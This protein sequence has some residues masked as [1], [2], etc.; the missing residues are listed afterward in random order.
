MNKRNLHIDL[1]EKYLDNSLRTDEVALFNE[2]LENEEEFVRD[3]NDMEV[4]IAGIKKAAA[5]TTIEE[6]IDRFERTV[7]ITENDEKNRI[8]FPDFEHIK[9]YSGAIAASLT[10]ILVTT[11]TLFNVNNTPDHQKLYA[12]YYMPFEN[13]GNKRSIDIEDKNYWKLALAYYDAGQYDAALANLDQIKINDFKGTFNSPSYHLYRGNTLM[14]LNRH[15]E[16]IVIFEKMIDNEDGMVIQAKWYLSM[17]YLH[18]NN[19]E[20]FLSLIKEIAKIEASSYG[21]KAQKVLDQ[22][23]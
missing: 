11:L 2:T 6:K 12:E 3:L 8:L 17:C 20:E 22:L 16:A 9:R 10:L 7:K 1:I 4:L 19:Q 15:P 21:Q 5:Q 14:Q 18:E 13:Q 23:K